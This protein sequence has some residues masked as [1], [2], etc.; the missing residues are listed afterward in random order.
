MLKLLSLDCNPLTNHCG[1]RLLSGMRSMPNLK[2]V[3]VIDT[4]LSHEIRQ[5]IETLRQL[6]R[7]PESL[8]KWE[9]VRLTAEPLPA[10]SS[11][12]SIRLV[13]ANSLS[14]SRQSSRR[15]SLS[16]NASEQRETGSSP[17]AES[18]FDSIA[19]PDEDVATHW[20][21]VHSLGNEAEDVRK[22]LHSDSD[23]EHFY[24]EVHASEQMH[25]SF[26]DDDS[27]DVEDWFEN[28]VQRLKKNIAAF[29][30]SKK[31]ALELSNFECA[32]QRHIGLL[33]LM[34][35]TLK[36]LPQSFADQVFARCSNACVV[37]GCAT[38]EALEIVFIIPPERYLQ[39]THAKL[40]QHDDELVMPSPGNCLLLR[41]DI[42]AL[43]RHH[44]IQFE[45]TPGRASVK[46]VVRKQDNDYRQYHARL[47]SSPAFSEETREFLNL[48]ST[49]VRED[50]L[51]SESESE[52]AE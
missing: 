10:I 5:D 2:V 3:W 39:L 47:V 20:R 35:R 49:L 8:A 29:E 32:Q 33:A 42:A 44:V 52:D 45:V 22:F 48:R 28:S 18:I 43:F 1:L 46:I 27:D 25:I 16:P 36:C 24:E 4:P 19:L 6:D 37:S 7:S 41:A 11:S 12:L 14:A 30:E 51:D 26:T 23:E 40:I 17:P 9:S 31:R 38:R 15:P 34:E 50:Q 21:S 13:F